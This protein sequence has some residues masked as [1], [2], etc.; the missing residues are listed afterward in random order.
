MVAYAKSSNIC[1]NKSKKSTKKASSLPNWLCMSIKRES[2]AYQQ[3][4]KSQKQD[5]RE[6][7][8]IKGIEGN[9]N[10][11]MT[12]TDGEDGTHNTVSSVD[13]VRVFVPSVSSQQRLEDG[14]DGW[15][16][17]LQ[18]GETQS[19]WRSSEKRSSALVHQGFIENFRI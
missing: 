8:R 4:L 17:A 13:D 16:L 18:R 15:V 9:P 5:L 11:Q 14:E 6:K 2:E 10:K 7:V 19:V 3:S 12:K 1:Y